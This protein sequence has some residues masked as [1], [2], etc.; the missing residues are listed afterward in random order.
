MTKGRPCFECS[1]LFGYDMDV[2]HNACKPGPV[3]RLACHSHPPLKSEHN[4]TCGELEYKYFCSSTFGKF[5][6]ETKKY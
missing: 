4:H 1:P 5:R 3:G 2:E 6:P